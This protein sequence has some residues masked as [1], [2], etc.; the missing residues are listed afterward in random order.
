MVCILQLS[1]TMSTDG[2]REDGSSL[3][4]NGATLGGGGGTSN[5]LS[6]HRAGRVVLGS[7]TATMHAQ[8]DGLLGT[9]PMR[10]KSKALQSVEEK[11]KEV[12]G[13]V[14]RAHAVVVFLVPTPT[15]WLTRPWKGTGAKAWV[16]RF[17]FPA[18]MFTP[19]VRI[20]ATQM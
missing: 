5:G 4:H 13:T 7:A 15:R 6:F 19:Y 8:L 16:F 18:E 11:L 17:G 2:G 1:L 20:H 9:L 12:R 10:A 14:P 3:L